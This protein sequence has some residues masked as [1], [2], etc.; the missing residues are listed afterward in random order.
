MGASD[1]NPPPEPARRRPALLILVHSDPRRCAPRVTEAIRVAA[2]LAAGSPG[3][4]SL[5]L[6]DAAVLA[7]DPA[8]PWPAEE[9]VLAPAWSLLHDSSVPIHVER[10]APHR[11]GLE[12]AAAPFVEID[13]PELNRLI[14]QASH[15]LNF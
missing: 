9:A 4:V 13:P 12:E 5:Y 6:H 15:V 2:G 7:L 1:F 11:L 14:A 3:T 8:G 10:D